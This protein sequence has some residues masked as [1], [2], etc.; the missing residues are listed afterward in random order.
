MA[1]RSMSNTDVVISTMIVRN[2]LWIGFSYVIFYA[3]RISNTRNLY[4]DPLGM[5]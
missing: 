1:K 4:I 3:V 5:N 2:C